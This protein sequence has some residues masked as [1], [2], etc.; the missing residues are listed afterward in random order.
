MLNQ[1]TS[2]KEIR[3]KSETEKSEKKLESE[4]KNNFSSGFLNPEQS[5]PHNHNIH[6]KINL[7][8]EHNINKKYENESESQSKYSMTTQK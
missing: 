5:R 4:T 3:P 7:F 6:P 8:S 1:T 2:Y